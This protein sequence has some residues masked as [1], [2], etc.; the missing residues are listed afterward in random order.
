[1]DTVLIIL[2]GLC[3]VAGIIGSLIPLLP[4]P[5]VSYLGLLLLHFTSQHPFSV[6]FLLI[7]ATLTVLVV[8][9]DNLVPIYGTKRFRGS[10]YGTWGTALGLVAGLLFFPP[11]GIIIGPVLGAF[12]GELISGKGTG[13]AFRSAVGSFLGFLAGTAVKV[14]LSLVMAYHF[15]R[16]V[17]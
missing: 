7:Y 11:F 16:I 5:P 3:I 9:L 15:I 4:G 13:Q 14:V 8:V 17:L 12:F 6:K 10:S 2:G 1:M